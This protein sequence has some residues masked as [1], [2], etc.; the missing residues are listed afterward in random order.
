[1]YQQ[2]PQLQGVADLLANQGRYGDSMLVHMNPVEVQG[3]ASMSPTGSLTVNPE[4]GQPEAFLPFLAPLLG[5]MLGSSALTGATLGGL[6]S[7]GLSSAAAGAIGSGL[8]SWASTGDLKQGLVS[9]ITGFGIGSALGGMGGAAKDAVAGTEGLGDALS[10]AVT[11]AGPGY[12]PFGA[13]SVADLATQA[14]IDAGVVLPE[15]VS[16]SGPSLGEVF[17]KEGISAIA[18]PE[19]LI[20]MGI[21]EDY[22]AQRLADE[23]MEK[24]DKSSGMMSEAELARQEE[25][26][27]ANSFPNIS[28]GPRPLG[29]DYG[30]Q[31]INTGGIVSLDPDD[32][33]RRVNGLQ[34]MISPTVRMQFGGN[35]PFQTGAGGGYGLLPGGT[36]LG[37]PGDDQAALRDPHVIT[38]WQLQDAYAQQGLPGFGPE[39]KYFTT[40]DEAGFLRDPNPWWR[41]RPDPNAP[42]PPEDG[43]DDGDN[44]PPRTPFLELWRQFQAGEI[45]W[46]EYRAR[47]GEIGRQSAETVTDET[48]TEAPQTTTPIDGSGLSAEEIANLYSQYMNYGSNFSG[49]GMQEGGGVREGIMRWVDSQ[50]RQKEKDERRKREVDPFTFDRWK[51]R[52][53]GEI[54]DLLEL[55]MGEERGEKKKT[56]W[57]GLPSAS[58]MHPMQI[59]HSGAA[60]EMLR[61]DDFVDSMQEG[62]ETQVNGEAD[63]LINLAAMAVLGELPEEEAD[64]VIQAFID[65]FGEEA[66]SSLREAVLEGVVPGSQKEGEIVGPGGGM[67]DQVMGMIGNQQP[68]AVSPGEYIVPADV[69]SGI[70]DGSTDA[71]VQELDGMLDRVRVDRTG[72]T[73]QPPPL[74]G[75]GVLPR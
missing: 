37:R 12:L 21:A 17:S 65:E 42:P 36:T 66:F 40:E 19:A 72:T 35:I 62:G 29:D 11:E 50:R 34:E 24:W 16:A 56:R 4:T 31:Y 43:G 15:A 18:S 9:G 58:G 14:G 13:D 45:T 32:Y 33:R 1:M 23:A 69:V 41:G 46:E 54:E 61:G 75:G 30:A 53:S 73:Q 8:A 49:I 47:I 63:R 55:I 27:I 28:S 71:G 51:A 38:P 70:G 68:V 2:Q 39:L 3:L 26:I 57:R 67:D 25:A 5:G 6:V 48:T 44:A 59:F 64:V 7:G 22:N 10:G 52:S 20:P 74:R 60:E